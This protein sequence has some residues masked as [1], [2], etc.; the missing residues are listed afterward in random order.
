MPSASGSIVNR[1]RQVLWIDGNPQTLSSLQFRVDPVSGPKLPK[2]LG[3]VQA[4]IEVPVLGA[5][6]ELAGRSVW[7]NGVQFAFPGQAIDVDVQFAI[8]FWSA[9]DS[10]LWYAAYG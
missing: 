4:A 9:V 8:I 2:R 1:G 3:Y 7:Y 10:G 5:T 6:F